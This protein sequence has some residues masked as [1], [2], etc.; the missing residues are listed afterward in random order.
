MDIPSNTSPSDTSVNNFDDNPEIVHSSNQR[1]RPVRAPAKRKPAATIPSQVFSSVASSTALS[2]G[3][4]QEGKHDGQQRKQQGKTSQIN[5]EGSQDTNNNRSTFTE[6]VITHYP[7]GKRGISI[8]QQAQVFGQG[9]VSEQEQADTTRG[10]IKTADQLAVVTTYAINIIP[11]GNLSPTLKAMLDGIAARQGDE[12]F[13]FVLA[14]NKSHGIQNWWLNKKRTVATQKVDPNNASRNPW[15]Q[16]IEAYN[17]LEGVTP[18]RNLKANLILVGLDPAG[19]AGS[20][21]SKQLIN[22]SGVLGVTGASLGHLKKENQIDSGAVVASQDLASSALHYFADKTLNHAKAVAR[23]TVEEGTVSLTKLKPSLFQQNLQQK[24]TTHPV[25]DPINPDT[26]VVKEAIKATFGGQ[27]SESSVVLLHNKPSTNPVAHIVN[28]VDSKP[29]G[30]ALKQLFD[31]AV[32]GDT[33]KIRNQFLDPA[34]RKLII[35]ALAKGVNIKLLSNYQWVQNDNKERVFAEHKALKATNPNVGDLTYVKTDPN[36]DF[37]QARGLPVSPQ[38]DHAKTYILEKGDRDIILTG[39]YNLDQQSIY[40]SSESALLIETQDHSLKK[41]LF[42]DLWQASSSASRSTTEATTEKS[43]QQTDTPAVAQPDLTASDSTIVSLPTKNNFLYGEQIQTVANKNN[44]VLAIRAPNEHSLGLLQEGYASKNFHIKA[45]SSSGG[46][47]AGFVVTDPMLSKVRGQGDAAIAKQQKTINEAK[48]KGAQEVQIELSESRVQ[49]L[50]N[51]QLIATIASNKS[52]KIIR[53]NYSNNSY[54]FFQLDK[55]TEGTWKLFHLPNYQSPSNPGGKIPVKGLT[56][57]PVPGAKSPAGS[58]AVVTAD[59]DLFGVWPTKNR[60]NNPRQINTAPR[61]I[62]GNVANRYIE[63]IRGPGEADPNMGN[64][65]TFTQQIVRQ[66]NQNV[67]VAGGYQGGYLFHHGDETGNPFS[68]GQDYPII[69]FIPGESK[70]Y[71]INNNTEL[72]HTYQVLKE[73]GFTVEVNPAFSFPNYAT[74]VKQTVQAPALSKQS[75]THFQLQKSTIVSAPEKQQYNH[76]VI[77]EVGSDQAV[78]LSAERLAGKYA[79]NFTRLKW[80]PTTHKVTTVDGIPMTNMPAITTNSRIFIVGHGQVNGIGD[81][82]QSTVSAEQLA[83]ALTDS[84]GAI[85]AAL[86]DKYQGES[87]GRISL[88]SCHSAHVEPSDINGF[89]AAL[90]KRLDE[91]GVTTTVSARPGYTYVDQNGRKYIQPR[92]NPVNA[93]GQPIKDPTIPQYRTKIVYSIEHGETKASVVRLNEPYLA[94]TK[95]TQALPGSNGPSQAELAEVMTKAFQSQPVGSNGVAT[96]NP[97]DITHIIPK[98]SRSVAE[99]Q[100]FSFERIDGKEKRVGKSG[101]FKFDLSHRNGLQLKWV[102]TPSSTSIENGEVF[103][104]YYLPYT[105]AG[106]QGQHVPYVDIPKQN[107]EHNFLFTGGLNGCSVIVCKHPTDATK[108]RVYHDSDPEGNNLKTGETKPY[109][110]EDIL[111]RLDESIYDAHYAVSHVTDGLPVGQQPRSYNGVA[112]LYYD[113]NT[114]EWGLH[115]RLTRNVATSSAADAPE[116][117]LSFQN[118]PL[119]SQ[120]IPADPTNFRV[121]SIDGNQFDG[122]FSKDGRFFYKEANSTQ[123]W[124]LGTEL[125]QQR[126]QEAH[127]DVEIPRLTYNTAGQLANPSLSGV[128]LPQFDKPFSYN[129]IPLSE[130]SLS[131]LTKDHPALNSFFASDPDAQF[132]IE[133]LLKHHSG[134]GE[135]FLHLKVELTSEAKNQITQIIE[136]RPVIELSQDKIAQVQAIVNEKNNYQLVELT[137]AKALSKGGKADTSTIY[138]DQVSTY[139]ISETTVQQQGVSHADRN[140]GISLQVIYNDLATAPGSKRNTFAANEVEVAKLR[141]L[142]AVGE[143]SPAEIAQLHKHDQYLRQ[144]GAIDKTGNSHLLAIK[145]QNVVSTTIDTLTE[146]KLAGAVLLKSVGGELVPAFTMTHAADNRVR[147]YNQHNQ[148]IKV[149]DNID[150]LNTKSQLTGYI[151]Q[152]VAASGGESAFKVGITKSGFDSQFNRQA[153]V[154]GA[155]YNPSLP[156]TQIKSDYTNI[157]ANDV[158]VGFE[159]K[160]GHR[161]GISKSEA[162][163]LG[164]KVD[165]K[166]ITADTDFTADLFMKG[167]RLSWDMDKASLVLLFDTQLD[168]S[169]PNAISPKNFNRNKHL[170][171][172]V[173]ADGTQQNQ[174]SPEEQQFIKQAKAALSS[175]GNYDDFINSFKQWADTEQAKLL[176]AV[177]LS[178][179]NHDQVKD[180]SIGGDGTIQVPGDQSGELSIK[181]NNTL[182]DGQKRQLLMFNTIQ[183]RQVS[184]QKVVSALSDGA[185][186]VISSKAMGAYSAFGAWNGIRLLSKFGIGDDPFSKLNAS[187]TILGAVEEVISGVASAGQ[188]AER[189][190]LALPKSGVNGISKL[191]GGTSKV[192]NVAGKIAGPLGI[193]T[194]GISIVSGAIGLD[195]AIKEGDNYGIASSSFD[196]VSGALGTAAGIMFLNPATAPAAPF[197]AI[198]ALVAAGISQAIQAAKTVNTFEEEVRPLSGWEKFQYGAAAFFGVD[199]TTPWHQELQDTR[200]KKAIAARKTLIAEQNEISQHVFRTVGDSITDTSA[201]FPTSEL[202]LFGKYPHT[203]RIKEKDEHGGEVHQVRMNPAHVLTEKRGFGDRNQVTFFNLNERFDPN[204]SGIEL[205]DAT[206]YVSH[207]NLSGWEYNRLAKTI[208]TGSRTFLSDYPLGGDG[209]IPVIEGFHNKEN[210]FYTDEAVEQS[211]VGGKKSDVVRYVAPAVEPEV[212]QETTRHR[213]KKLYFL[214]GDGQDTAAFSIAAASDE[215]AGASPNVIRVRPTLD[216]EYEWVYD[217]DQKQKIRNQLE[218][219]VKIT[220]TATGSSLTAGE[221]ET[222][223]IQGNTETSEIDADLRVTANQPLIADKTF[224]LGNADNL[225]LR[226]GKGENNT[227][228]IAANKAVIKSEANNNTFYIADDVQ[229]LRINNGGLDSGESNN[230]DLTGWVPLDNLE[231]FATNDGKGIRIRDKNNHSRFIRIEDRSSITINVQ[232]QSGSS[233]KLDVNK[234]LQ[235][236][237]QAQPLTKLLPQNTYYIAGGTQQIS[238][239]TT[240]SQLDVKGK[241]TFQV[242]TKNSQLSRLDV[243]QGVGIS[244]DTMFEGSQLRFKGINFSD[245]QQSGNTLSVQNGQFELLSIKQFSPYTS[246]VALFDDGI[247]SFRSDAQGKLSVY[248]FEAK[249]QQGLTKPEGVLNINKEELGFAHVDGPI[250]LFRNGLAVS[251]LSG[252]VYD[253]QGY[254]Y[255]NA[256]YDSSKNEIVY[257]TLN[258]SKQRLDPSQVNARIAPYEATVL[259]DGRWLFGERSDSHQSFIVDPGTWRIYTD[260]E[261]SEPLKGVWFRYDGARGQHL[262]VDSGSG[263]GNRLTYYQTKGVSVAEFQRIIQDKG[264]ITDISKGELYYPDAADANKAQ[265]LAYFHFIIGQDGFREHTVD[266]SLHQPIQSTAEQPIVKDTE[267]NDVVRGNDG[268]NI[269]IISAGSDRVQPNAGQNQLRFTPRASGIKTVELNSNEETVLWLPFNIST[270]ADYYFRGDSFVIEG[271]APNASGKKLRVI[272]P[273]F[274]KNNPQL[275]LKMYDAQDGDQVA[276][277]EAGQEVHAKITF[278][279][280]NIAYLTML[281]AKRREVENMQFT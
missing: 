24:L 252:E 40:R 54:E 245:I 121:F 272:I 235:V 240:Q 229:S 150:H 97:I 35:D 257:N 58:K 79:D 190:K 141:E 6:K 228:H 264:V 273:D 132:R 169:R 11:D 122:W 278:G 194:G 237:Q 221:T 204:R 29:I 256:K 262:V 34:A 249:P 126:F 140:R 31:E 57:P 158:T 98:E 89:G 113:Q 48:Q 22:D 63:H 268:N 117:T 118:H 60:S 196:I 280:S 191:L 255:A 212:N 28:S 115:H 136:N 129:N 95:P 23:V 87:V 274:E 217:Y 134:E 106:P 265:L 47:T 5:S 183:Q 72:K 166:N 41:S 189:F 203:L 156:T 206:G 165:G 193:V 94:Y 230:I 213:N 107:P 65:A 33:I 234:L 116:L 149:F 21:H 131:Q 241:G 173:F 104:A 209:L 253:I 219:F 197:V 263:P 142:V 250:W 85:K 19:P 148:L 43:Q 170:F 66:L 144:Q 109:S 176:Q 270:K 185:S 199:D 146:N 260:T 1:R 86:G 123:P 74:A 51:S 226:T 269:L 198:A 25:G 125:Y 233:V 62:N 227:F 168:A 9:F 167:N 36:E 181:L 91:K 103:G 192:G 133:N 68:P 96:T 177:N 180:I 171:M 38:F 145:E 182:T 3:Q 155:A 108:L 277:L 164:L 111:V 151:N 59:Y 114:G 154:D 102:S 247:V 64:I 261:D 78:S 30:L 76:N 49:Y 12:N 281:A 266:N 16:A 271:L 184:R 239:A 67:E 101:Y 26:T 20:H 7:K 88:V 251:P 27:S 195:R 81:D 202:F 56:N 232:G 80:D 187:S 214:G 53:G 13:S 105:G 112:F 211:Y 17:Q 92:D 275:T 84:N 82:L 225:K 246:F 99:G 32:A 93:Q 186:R 110:N 160:D 10:V 208:N 4:K 70:P 242:E 224:I 77:I 45:K 83:S 18:I 162:Y 279:E 276:A 46:P 236:G 52:S 55:T 15:I 218:S 124:K 216:F 161:I 159:T 138:Q 42:D 188:I 69:L 8:D 222:L 14:Y 163:R 39:T 157:L 179:S 205:I 259:E 71:V 44:T 267:E 244:L 127:P 50:E 210:T 135:N 90:V 215:H 201:L 258:N 100:L 231:A 130:V 174:S 207:G 200:R 137:V 175:A 61:P 119:L 243:D 178:L 143:A 147:I 220:E 128:R 37:K 139:G 152:M 248:K 75:S 172:H 254:R 73:T 223:L 120:E 2:I 153:I 238:L